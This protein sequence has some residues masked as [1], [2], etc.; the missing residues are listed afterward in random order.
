MRERASELVRMQVV[1][2][3]LGS[4]HVHPLS[5]AVWSQ[6]PALGEHHHIEVCPSV[7]SAH[8]NVAIYSACSPGTEVDRALS[9]RALMVLRLSGE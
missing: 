4:Q 3:G 6:R 7:T 1:Q 5:D 8:P 2:P 9:S